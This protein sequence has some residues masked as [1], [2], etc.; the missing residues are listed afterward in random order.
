MSATDRIERIDPA[1]PVVWWLKVTFVVLG[2]MIAWALRFTFG[3]LFTPASCEVGAW[4]QWLISGVFILIGAGALL[5][6]LLMLRRDLDTATR[7]LLFVGVALNVFFLGVMLLEMTAIAVV[8]A[9]AKG[10]IP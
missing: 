4:L 6:N 10:A 2:A 8:D 7:F 9:C 3:Y 1:K 5:A